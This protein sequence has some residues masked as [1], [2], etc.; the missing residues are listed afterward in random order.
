MEVYSMIKIAGVDIFRPKDMVV[1]KTAIIQAEYTTCTGKVCGDIVGTK[2]SDD[3]E[4]TWDCLT[5]EMVR[6]LSGMV[7][8]ETTMEFTDATGTRQTAEILISGLKGTPTRVTRSDGT[9]VFT[10]LACSVRMIGAAK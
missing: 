5:D 3:M 9:A 4:L 7:G 8:K 1:E 10:D 2:Y 6:K